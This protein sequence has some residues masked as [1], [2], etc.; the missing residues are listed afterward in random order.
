MPWSVGPRQRVL[1][2]ND[3]AGDP[4]GLA[5]LAH[6]LL[7]PTDAVVAVTSSRL[8]PMFDQV[9]GSTERGAAFARELLTLAGT[10]EVPVAGGLDDAFDG[11]PRTSAAA[12][13]I[14]DEAQRDSP[15]PL[16]VVCGGPLTNI[17]DALTVRPEIADR[18][19]LAWVGGGLGPVD[20]EYNRDTDA[21]A[22]EY[23]L[24]S[25]ALEIRQ[26][27]MEVYRSLAISVAELEDGLTSAGPVGR[28]LWQ[29]Y[30]DLPIP[31]GVP[32][33]PMWPLGDS[34]P[35]VLTALD[36]A[37]ARYAR[38]DESRPN[39]TVCTGLDSRLVI[40]DF[41]ARLRLFADSAD[42]LDGTAAS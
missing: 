36:N 21:A 20:F 22:A 33:G 24:S 31:P 3:W 11:M 1:V 18:I 29:K 28:W 15:L 6:H 5:A 4:D 35:L 27:P 26:Y 32:I 12:E 30:E 40:G 19:T 9:P 7:S 8:N 39:L 42:S 14:V 34:A 17:A 41:F 2:D 16:V 13:L 10:A 38:P 23:V 25:S 37:T